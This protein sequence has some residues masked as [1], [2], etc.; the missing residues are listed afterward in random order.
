MNVIVY[1]YNGYNV[2]E[3]DEILHKNLMKYWDGDYT[4]FRS[5]IEIP[6]KGVYRYL[7][8]IEKDNTWD[9]I[10]VIEN[11]DNE[12]SLL[13]EEFHN[14]KYALQWLVDEFC[15]IDELKRED[16]KE[17]LVYIS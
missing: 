5:D 13:G 6:V 10:Y 17:Q 4:E 7:C 12:I 3:I 8:Y 2:A 1:E 16:N 11:S 15:D 14:K 9:A